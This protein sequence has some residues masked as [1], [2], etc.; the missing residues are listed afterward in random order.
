MTFAEY[1]NS[2]GRTS[3]A[4]NTLS[5]V[6]EAELREHLRACDVAL[7]DCAECGELYRNIGDDGYVDALTE[8]MEA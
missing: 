5:S 7:A 3:E 4:V 1:V 8:G 6:R 2:E